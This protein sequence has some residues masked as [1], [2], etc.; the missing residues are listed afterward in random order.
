MPRN[1]EARARRPQAPAR[2]APLR[3]SA[4]DIAL[5]GHESAFQ[6]LKTK[7]D[8]IAAEHC[9][10]GW[11]YVIS[12]GLTLAVAVPAYYLS[13]D[14][15]AKAIYGVA[16]TIGVGAVGYG[17]YLVLVAD[18]HTR[19]TRLIQSMPDLTPSQRDRLARAFLVENAERARNVRKIRVI[20]HSLT[21]ALNISSGL[22][23]SQRELQ[24]ALLFIGGINTLAALSFAF[25]R[26]EEEKLADTLAS[27]SGGLRAAP[28]L[29]SG[30][31][32]EGA[33]LAL[34][35]DF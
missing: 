7:S 10:N 28:F 9:T 22:T 5:P 34:T 27:A 25:S 20:S 2:R 16:Q 23:A 11:A 17:S 29:V 4:P 8:L 12:G 30:V 33:G 6:L 14:I 1:P 26:S 35:L 31:R 18:D 13:E 24:T 3:P 21:A 15:F 32:G 19:M